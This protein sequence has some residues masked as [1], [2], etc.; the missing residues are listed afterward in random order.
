MS[1]PG[2]LLEIFDFE[3]KRCKQHFRSYDF[4]DFVYG[5]RLMRTVRGDMVILSC[6]N[7]S[8]VAEIAEMIK[9]I[10]STDPGII[11]AVAFD[12]VVGRTC[13]PIDGLEPGVNVEPPCPHC[14]SLST[15]RYNDL[16]PAQFVTLN[17]PMATHSRWRVL[18]DDQ[19]LSLIQALLRD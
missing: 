5:M 4:S 17:V 19:K 13:D 9:K 11:P 8:V 2:T 18:S 7:N 16:V 14:D 3:C 1:D 6:L 15:T 12:L 10:A